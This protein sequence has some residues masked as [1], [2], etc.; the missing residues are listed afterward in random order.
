MHARTVLE[1]SKLARQAAYRKQ[2]EEEFR[3]AEERRNDWTR[4]KHFG[5][6]FGEQE[7]RTWEESEKQRQNSE[8]DRKENI[9]DKNTMI[10]EK[11]V[12]TRPMTGLCFCDINMRD[13]IM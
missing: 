1:M 3:I 5:L 13:C 11:V 6:D 8:E 10:K 12:M 7:I 4:R 2:L 9:N